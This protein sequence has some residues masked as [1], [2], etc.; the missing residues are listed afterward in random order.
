MGHVLS[1]IRHTV[2]ATSR[3]RHGIAPIVHRT[4]LSA[5]QVLS[6]THCN[7][8]VTEQPFIIERATHLADAP[9]PRLRGLVQGVQQSLVHAFVTREQVSTCLREVICEVQLQAFFHET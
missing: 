1:A 4:V 3:E 6:P 2:I 7:F 5:T 8:T 9:S